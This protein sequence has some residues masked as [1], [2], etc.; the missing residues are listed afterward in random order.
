MTG[1]YYTILKVCL[2]LASSVV[3]KAHFAWLGVCRTHL[4]TCSRQI[5]NICEDWGGEVVTENDCMFAQ[6]GLTIRKSGLKVEGI[7]N[8]HHG[9]MGSFLS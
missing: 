3:F 2:T 5:V 6:G 7:G 4:K 1:I 9:N 8:E